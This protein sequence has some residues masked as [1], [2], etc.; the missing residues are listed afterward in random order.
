MSRGGSSLGSSNTGFP[1]YMTDVHQEWL[2]QGGTPT[3]IDFDMVEL[4]NVAFGSATPFEQFDYTDPEGWLEDIETSIEDI[5]ET[6]DALDGETDWKAYMTKAIAEVATLMDTDY[7]TVAGNMATAW[8]D[9]NTKAKTEMATIITDGHISTIIAYFETWSNI[10]DNAITKAS[11]A[12]PN[13]F[14]TDAKNEIEIWNTV[15]DEAISKANTTITDTFATDA[16]SEIELWN[17]IIDEAKTK[18]DNI[19]TNSFASDAKSEIEA[20][21]TIMD[22]AKSKADSFFN[23]SAIDSKVV[24]YEGKTLPSY[25]KEIARFSG[26]MADINA[27]NS[28]AYMIGLSIIAHRRLQDTNSFRA[29]LRME[30][31]KELTRFIQGIATLR[32]DI[33]KNSADVYGTLL[34]IHARIRGEFLHGIAL[35]RANINKNSADVYGNLLGLH[36]RLRKEFIQGIGELRANI[37]KNSANIYGDLLGIHARIRKEFIEST[38]TLAGEIDYRKANVESKLRDAFEDRQ[39]TFV[40]KSLTGMVEMLLNQTR[41]RVLAVN[42]G[43]AEMTK[44]DITTIDMNKAFTSLSLEFNRMRIVSN[45]EYLDRTLDLDI[46]H[47]LWDMNVYQYGTNVLSG[48]G[49]GGQIMPE[50]I[51]A[52]QSA[53]GGALSGAALGISAGANPAVVAGGAILG[54]IAGYI[55]G[56]E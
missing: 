12:I 1:T 40:L 28:S 16:K 15:I 17:L 49:A 43:I 46:K 34:G 6:L 36:A 31:E 2:G 50:R 3:V 23:D 39:A 14:A 5:V 24:A 51:S 55:A 56:G 32:A 9:L 35:L 44:Y 27:V 20:W 4:M 54:G 42:S 53:L 45:Q 11:T 30:Y 22:E 13:T 52:G 25:Q 10:T 26:G 18:A 48:I 33:N 21:A 7:Q 19:I 41:L 37:N 47:T 8:A 29:D 38:S